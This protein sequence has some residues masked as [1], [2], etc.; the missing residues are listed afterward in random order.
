MAMKTDAQFILDNDMVYRKANSQVSKCLRLLS[1]DRV[2]IDSSSDT[3]SG[4]VN[5]NEVAKWGLFE[6]SN[7]GG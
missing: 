5:M 2:K 7:L 6:Q 4:K 1:Q 3:K